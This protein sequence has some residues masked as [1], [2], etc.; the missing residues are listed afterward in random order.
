MNYLPRLTGITGK[1]VALLFP[2]CF[3]LL[4]IAITGMVCNVNPAGATTNRMTSGWIGIGQYKGRVVDSVTEK[5]LAGV[6]VLVWWTKYAHHVA[7]F[8]VILRDS[9]LVTTD[10][11]G[12]YKIAGKMIILP[13]EV[14]FLIYQPGYQVITGKGSYRDPSL[15]I[16]KEKTINLERIPPFFD[17]SKQM[18]TINEALQSYYSGKATNAFR[19]LKKS[20]RRRAD[21]ET[22]RFYLSS[23][24]KN[25]YRAKHEPFSPDLEKQLR[26]KSAETRRLAARQLGF[27]RDQRAVKPLIER[28]NDKDFLVRYEAAFSWEK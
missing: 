8:N 15:I 16:N 5:P 18:N 2:V 25:R 24:E 14:H 10:D 19:L 17:H 21:W 7:G 4:F 26:D 20:I 3:S 27:C 1:R 13:N 28:L 9:V 22:R 23:P 6:S 11:R 12:A